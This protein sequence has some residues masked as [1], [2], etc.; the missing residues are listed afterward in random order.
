MIIGLSE[1]MVSDW[2]NHNP[3]QQFLKKWGSDLLFRI[4]KNQLP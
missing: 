2:K 4:A 3:I 1:R